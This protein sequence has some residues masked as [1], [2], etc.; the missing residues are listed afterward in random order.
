MFEFLK[1]LI[2]HNVPLDA[3][4]LKGE[5]GLHL[6]S[7]NGDIEAVEFLLARGANVKILTLDNNSASH[8]AAMSKNDLI[9]A[10]LN[11][12]GLDPNQKN[13]HGVSATDMLKPQL[14]IIYAGESEHQNNLSFDN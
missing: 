7:Y 10:V 3:K 14:F 11:K 9:V 4:N 5:T 13:I 8:Y 1:L 6:A 2:Q 12:S